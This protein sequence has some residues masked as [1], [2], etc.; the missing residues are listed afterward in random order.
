MKKLL[1]LMMSFIMLISLVSMSSVVKAES[2][3]LTVGTE[4]QYDTLTAA[5]TAA[6]DG[7]TIQLLEDI[8]QTGAT[9]SKSI[10]IDTNGH[11][12]T[13]GTSSKAVSATISANVTIKNSQRTTQ[14]TEEATFDIVGNSKK[15]YGVF[16]V[17][18]NATLNLVNIAAKST[19]GHKNN[20]PCVVYISGTNSAL[21]VNNCYLTSTN[22][23]AVAAKTDLA[24]EV[25]AQN[26]IFGGSIASVFQI[27]SSSV[28]EST[29][30]FTNCTFLNSISLAA[31][32]NAESVS[33]AT[34]SL[35]GISYSFTDCTATALYGY[36]VQATFTGTNAFT[37]VYA[38]VV[39]N[40]GEN[41]AL[42]ADEEKSST[43]LSGTKLT[44]DSAL[45][46]EAANGT[47]KVYI[48]GEVFDEVEPGTQVTLPSSTNKGFIAY[49][50]GVNYYDEGDVIIPETITTLAS[51]TVGTFEMVQGAAMKL[52]LKTGIR[53]YTNVNTDAIAG[54]LDKGAEIS[55]GTLI[56]PKDLLS[57]DELTLEVDEEKRVDVPFTPGV[58]DGIWFEEGTFEGMVGS[59]VNL[60]TTTEEETGNENREFVGRGY[61]T[62]TLGEIT[63]T[64]YASYAGDDVANN[65]RTISYIANAIANDAGNVDLYNTYKTT[66]DYF[67]S[68]YSA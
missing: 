20:Q 7:D 9:I 24:I 26:S 8:T 47:F 10:T 58:T 60:R 44:E 42:F 25:S 51:V 6:N 64:I 63:K 66:I 3:T 50:D 19:N 40:S 39:V 14:I 68:F 43:I 34:N 62:V 46:T 53:Y 21:N 13:G 16:D 12:W 29:Y 55:M 36:D 59:I 23:G 67:A 32:A 5:I 4:G 49:T 54:L 31:A 33:S 1:S 38:N 56:A 17:S 18:A 37:T 22:F 2:R 15:N 41:T 61:I 28:A 48:D 52:N 57:G 45:Y 35:S 30:S 65:T 27:D 11:V